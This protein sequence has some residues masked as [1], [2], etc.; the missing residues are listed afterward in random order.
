MEMTKMAID[1]TAWNTLEAVADD[2]F[3]GEALLGLINNAESQR[4]SRFGLVNLI[5]CQYEIILPVSCFVVCQTC[6][7][8]SRALMYEYPRSAIR[9][10]IAIACSIYRGQHNQVLTG[11]D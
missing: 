7:L 6:T 2:E 5:Q 3:F 9:G 4:S 1:V 11:C 8:N 10:C